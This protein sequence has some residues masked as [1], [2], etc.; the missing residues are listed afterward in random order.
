MGTATRSVTIT[1]NSTTAPLLEFTSGNSY[2]VGVAGIRFNEGTGNQNHIRL[3][4]T[5]SKVP[6]I[7]DCYFQVKCRAG[8]N[9]D[10]AA[11]AVLSQGGVFWNCIWSGE[12]FNGCAGGVQPIGSEGASL[13][14]NSPRAWYTPST[15][16][17]Q[18]TGGTVNVYIEDSTCVVVGQFPDIDDN[19][20]LVMRYSSLN[21]CGGLTHGYSSSWGGRHFEYYN[22]TLLNTYDGRNFGRYFWA[23]AGHGV[24]TDN[25]V[26]CTNT[27]YGIPEVMDTTCE[28]CNSYPEPR[29]VGWGHNGTKDVID[30]IYIWN[31]SGGSCRYDWET[32][33]PTYIRLNRELYVNSGAKPGYIKY[34]YPHPLRGASSAPSPPSNLRIDN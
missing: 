31:H 18:D 7:N 6:L 20:R 8:N 23:R 33:A 2:H 26:D 3:N 22:N 19:G 25:S 15:L 11:V 21:G 9:P 34:P 14:I 29:Q 5:G 32:N 28:G 17:T 16:G 10:I 24:F 12:A 1:N 30:P 4:G 13:L 27:G